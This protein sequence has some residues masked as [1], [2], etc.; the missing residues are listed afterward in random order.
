MYNTD[1]KAASKLLKVSIRTVDRYIKSGKLPHEVRDGRIW[2]NKKDVARMKQSKVVDSPV[3]MSTGGLSIDNEVSTP[4]D[5]SIDGVHIV[6]TGESHERA[7]KRSSGDQG[8][9]QKLFEEL[10]IELK[11]K[12]E[13]LEGANYRVGQLEAQ[14]ND[15]VP[16]QDHNRLLLSERSQKE[17]HM[18]EQQ[19]LMIQ[20]ELLEEKL[21]DEQFSKRVFL[22]FLFIIML[23]QPLWLILSL[24]K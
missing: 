21:K 9:Y 19:S 6:S 3:D 2:L 18:A 13:R 23:L 15:S 8:V 20:R 12:Q 5:M 17:H 11:T 4:V 14:L 22:I 16:L 24:K 1:R 10:Q 7:E